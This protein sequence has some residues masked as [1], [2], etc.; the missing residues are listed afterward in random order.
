MR[1]IRKT[2]NF[3][4]INVLESLTQRNKD[5]NILKSPGKGRLQFWK[6]AIMINQHKTRP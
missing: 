4:K 3:Q 1:I 2:K 5:F 6:S